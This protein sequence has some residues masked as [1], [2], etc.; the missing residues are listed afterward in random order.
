MGEQPVAG[1]EPMALTQQVEELRAKLGRLEVGL[2]AIVDPLVWVDPDGRVQWYNAPFR[3][4]V[5]QPDAVVT[6]ANLLDLLPLAANGA[7]L[8]PDRH[9]VSLALNGHPTTGDCYEFSKGDRRMVLEIFGARVQFSKHELNAVFAIHD[10]TQRKDAQAKEREL[11]AAAAASADAARKRAA[12]LDTAYRELRSAHNM[13]IQAE[14]MAAIGQLASG[15]AHEVKN[16]LGIILQ[17]VNYLETTIPADRAED[18]QVLQM[19]KE[20]VLRS[21]KIVRDML[22]FARQQPLEQKPCDINA[23][24][25]TALALVGKQFTVHNIAVVEELDPRLPQV[26][27]DENQIQQVLLNLLINSLQAMPQG[28]TITLSTRMANGGRLLPDVEQ[29]FTAALRPQERALVCQVRDTGQGMSPERQGRAFEPF[30]TTKPAGQGTGLGLAISRSIIEKHRGAI[31]L[32]SVERQG[33]TVSIA[34]PV[35]NGEVAP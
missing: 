35:A 5:D 30:F 4:L 31:W 14:K 16:P 27:L 3:R 13:L 9:P 12:E 17:G 21:D 33:T 26:V 8:S 6:G 7:C 15:V 19:I 29:R 34:L 11:A 22:H 18:R 28:G 2:S 23:V 10:V 24:V 32:D 25:R 20:A 1:I